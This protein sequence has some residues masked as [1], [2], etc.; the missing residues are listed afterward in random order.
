MGYQYP[1]SLEVN[2]KVSRIP[3]SRLENIPL[4]KF[5][6]YPKSLELNKNIPEITNTK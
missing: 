3:L 6:K 1:I 2:R 5:P 4:I